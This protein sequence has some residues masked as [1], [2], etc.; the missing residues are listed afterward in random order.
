MNIAVKECLEDILHDS[1]RFV[2]KTHELIHNILCLVVPARFFLLALFLA[3]TLLLFLVLGSWLIVR[4]FVAG[5]L[6]ATRDK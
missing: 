2:V 5:S 4:G 3:L 1:E 6:A